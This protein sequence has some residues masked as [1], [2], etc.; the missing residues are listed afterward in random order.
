MEMYGRGT[1]E[2][3]NASNEEFQKALMTAYRTYAYYH[4]THGTK[5]GREFMH[6]ISTADDQ[7]YFGYEREVLAPTVTEAVEATRGII[8]TYDDELAIT[9][10]FSRSD[11]RT[12]DWSEVWGGEVAWA[13]SVDVPCDYGKTMWG[14]GVG[15][16]AQGALCM[17]NEGWVWDDILTYF[18]T[19][20]ELQQWWE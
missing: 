3:S 16:S 11:G 8:V 19:D 7:V 10:Y 18:Y 15:M 14:H 20:T 1:G 6:L 13:K 5:R 17:G 2:T 4:Y 9:P 12:R